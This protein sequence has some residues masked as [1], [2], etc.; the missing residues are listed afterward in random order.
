MLNK[1]NRRTPLINATQ[2]F[3]TL[4]AVIGVLWLLMH[5]TGRLH[6]YLEVSIIAV[7]GIGLIVLTIRNRDLAKAEVIPKYF[8]SPLD[9]L[10]VAILILDYRGQI[11]FTNQAFI[12]LSGVD[13]ADLLGQKIKLLPWKWKDLESTSSE[14]SLIE[15]VKECESR[16]GHLVGPPNTQDRILVMKGSAISEESE[17][18]RGA[19][20]IFEDVT[21][22]QRKQMELSNLLESVRQSGNHIRQQNAKLELLANR[23]QLTGAYNRRHGMELLERLWSDARRFRHN[24]ICILVNLDRFREVNDQL[25][26]E[27]ADTILKRIGEL[28]LESVAEDAVVSRNGGKEFLVILP[29]TSFEDGL[30]FCEDLRK[31][32][33]RVT[34]SASRVTVSMGMS[35]LSEFSE[36][37]QALLAHADNYLQTAKSRGRNQFVYR[38]EDTDNLDLDESSLSSRIDQ[39]S[40]IP[41]PAVTA[42]ISALSFRD[43]ATAAHCRRVADLCVNFGQPILSQSNCYVLEM[44]ALLHDIGKIGI[45]DSTLQKADKLTT[46]DWDTLRSCERISVEIIR[47]SFATPELTEIV[48]NAIR[49]FSATIESGIQIPLGA[50]ILAVADAYDSM[51]NHKIY[52]SAM[53]HQQ[54]VAELQRCAGEQ[55]DPEIVEQFVEFMTS[56]PQTPIPHLQVPLEAALAFGIELERLAEAVDLQDVEELKLIAGQICNTANRVGAIEIS[57]KAMELEQIAITGRDILG[58]LCCA[59]E[60]LTYCRATQAAFLNTKIDSIRSLRPASSWN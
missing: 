19:M 9:D 32:I 52:R 54:A 53:S 39:V 49:P 6:V 22:F 50:R 58:C 13:R 45:P 59:N 28:L 34:P 12:E 40:S 21:K 17:T 31:Q 44:A 26:H 25:G 41:F 35:S 57:A 16:C 4:C 60:L 15:A 29:K 55:F 3:V 10:N 43:F 5:S 18:P 24:L 36:S 20:I 48:E 23:D 42:L 51:V 27:T 7:L 2:T 8:Q 56:Q 33:T 46:E 14:L 30:K 11:T 38:I 47:T 37:A 1:P